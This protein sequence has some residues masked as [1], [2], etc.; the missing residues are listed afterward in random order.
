MP[1]PTIRIGRKCKVRPDGTF[2]D[3]EDEYRLILQDESSEIWDNDGH[4]LTDTFFHSN[5]GCGF[6]FSF[7]PD[8]NIQPKRFY[9]QDGTY[10][11][12]YKRAK[13]S[14]VTFNVD[15][16]EWWNRSSK[17]LFCLG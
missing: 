13:S 17:C 7:D 3:C 15:S 16:P 9:K 2:Y 4:G 10:T 6:L 8:I 5:N 1:P 12:K 11:L 14:P